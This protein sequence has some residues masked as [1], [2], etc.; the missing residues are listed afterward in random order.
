M[1]TGT[2]VGGAGAD[3]R[4]WI[5][6]AGSALEERLR[7]AILN[8]TPVLYCTVEQLGARLQMLSQLMG[9]SAVARDMSA[10]MLSLLSCSS[11][12][13][14]RNFDAFCSLVGSEAVAREA[15]YTAPRLLTKH[16]ARVVHQARLEFWQGQLGLPAAQVLAKFGTLILSSLPVVGPRWAWLRKHRPSEELIVNYCIMRDSACMKKCKVPLEGFAEFKAAWLA[17]EE[18]RAACRHEGKWYTIISG[19]G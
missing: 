2:K 14:Q 13:L 9:S 6:A 19:S 17:S 16:F 1:E 12:R 18:G 3:I 11:A 4:L 5:P 15:L 10:R 8:H 7:K